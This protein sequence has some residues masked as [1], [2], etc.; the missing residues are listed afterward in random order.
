MPD[1]TNDQNNDDSWSGRYPT[2]GIPPQPF[3]V[4]IPEEVPPIITERLYLRSI[5]EDDVEGILKTWLS[6]PPEKAFWHPDDPEPSIEA[7]HDWR[8]RKTFSEPPLAA[9]RN[10]YF[11]IIQ[12]SDPT[13]QVIGAIGMNVVTPLPNVGYGLHYDVWGKGYATEA[14]QAV[15][16]AWWELPREV[17]ADDGGV[18]IGVGREKVVANAVK[19]NTASMRVLEKCGFTVYAE[20]E[21]QNG[22]IVC[23]L[24]AD[25]P[26]VS[27]L[28]KLKSLELG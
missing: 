22:D 21:D 5:R 27:K 11:V 13:G 17:P 28:K 9:G 15:L 7:V 10:F 8:K 20:G 6:Q 12:R 3:H 24:S 19:S 25:G 26:D 18:G 16:K 14:L 4:L 2:G 23:C 1:T